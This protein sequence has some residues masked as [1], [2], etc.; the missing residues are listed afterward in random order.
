MGNQTALCGE[1]HHHDAAVK[2]AISLLPPEEELAD[3][4]E[5]FKVFGDATRINILYLLSEGELCVC[6]IAAALHLTQPAVSYQLKALK[7]AR[8]VKNRRAGKTVFYSLSDQ[9]VA[10]IIGMAKEHL[11]ER[12]A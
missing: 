9:H 10:T 2:A 3:L 11:E 4:A 5:L 12:R 6:D 1:V 8:L 7:G